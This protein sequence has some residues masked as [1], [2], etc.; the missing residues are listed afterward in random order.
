MLGTVR[1]AVTSGSFKLHNTPKTQVP[2]YAHCTDGETEAQSRLVTCP[3]PQT[4]SMGQSQDVNTWSQSPTLNPQAV[5][6]H[7]R[8]GG[9]QPPDMPILHGS[10][11]SEAES[12]REEVTGGSTDGGSNP[13]FASLINHAP[14]PSQA[15]GS[16]HG[17]CGHEFWGRKPGIKSRH[18]FC[19]PQG[20]SL[21]RSL[22]QFPHLSKGIATALGPE[23]CWKDQGN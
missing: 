6:R 14:R 19:V 20:G 10:A 9:T 17:G 8:R 13:S 5:N 2:S 4:V 11:C 7:K 21:K 3:G 18:R 23:G 15:R 16:L 12:H 22:P 1:R